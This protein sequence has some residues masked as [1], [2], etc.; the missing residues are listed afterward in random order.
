MRLILLGGDGMRDG[1]KVADPL[2]YVTCLECGKA[3][4][5]VE[6]RRYGLHNEPPREDRTIPNC[7]R[8]WTKRTSAHPGNTKE[9]DRRA[10]DQFKAWMRAPSPWE[11]DE[12]AAS[13][14][15]KLRIA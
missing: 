13:R 6:E 14:F 3:L 7:R 2:P 4:I 10:A 12:Q 15:A 1:F 9:S 8:L 11:T 5:H